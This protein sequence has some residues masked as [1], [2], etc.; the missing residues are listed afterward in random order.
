MDPVQDPTQPAPITVQKVDEINLSHFKNEI[1]RT[2]SVPMSLKGISFR[3]LKVLRHHRIPSV[4]RYSD[5]LFI[6]NIVSCNYRGLR[7]REFI[8]KLLVH[9]D[10]Y[11]N[12][13]NLPCPYSRVD[14]LLCG[15]QDPEYNLD[16]AYTQ[17]R[18]AV[19]TLIGGKSYRYNRWWKPPVAGEQSSPEEPEMVQVLETP[20]PTEETKILD[21]NNRFAPLFVA[22]DEGEEP[23]LSVREDWVRCDHYTAIPALEDLREV[24][25][26]E[27]NAARVRLGYAPRP[28]DQEKV[29]RAEIPT[30]RRDL[31]NSLKTRVVL[32][33]FRWRE[34]VLSIYERTRDPAVLTHA[35]QILLEAYEHWAQAVLDSD[36][37]VKPPR[38]KKPPGEW[39]VPRIWDTDHR[40]NGRRL[41]FHLVPA[42][43]SQM[44][45]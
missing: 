4:V 40:M 36:L 38:L 12:A 25:K 19:D 24:R 34:D 10:S 23:T 37:G 45:G 1:V 5:T 17:L 15:S 39:D 6:R 30:K 18:R 11:N 44:G 35:P 2:A 31:L 42:T 9:I 16:W 22:W 33:L 7:P 26:K 29:D 21:T 20:E 41:S 27:A 14:V 32:P 13:L 8:I 28:I 3:L 43:P